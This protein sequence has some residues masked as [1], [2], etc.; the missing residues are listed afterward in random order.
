MEAVIVG[1][2]NVKGSEDVDE[3]QVLRSNEPNHLIH[4]F[5]NRERNVNHNLLCAGAKSS[6]NDGNA[7]NLLGKITT[8]KETSDEASKLSTSSYESL[9]LVGI[10]Y[11]GLNAICIVLSDYQSADRTE[12]NRDKLIVANEFIKRLR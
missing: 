10:H 6:S 9:V 5:A 1:K 12:E 7:T 11:R 8:D 3:R 2:S 4:G